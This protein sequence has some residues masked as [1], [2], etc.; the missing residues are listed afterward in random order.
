M[1]GNLLKIVG[2]VILLV[3]LKSC[4]F[5]SKTSHALKITAEVETPQGVRTGSSVIE[6][7]SKSI[8][9]WLPGS[10]G[11][12]LQLKGESPV[13]NLGNGKRLFVLL[14]DEHGKHDVMDLF[15]QPHSETDHSLTVD[16]Y[17][18]LVT[19]TDP[20]DAASVVKVS[21]ENFTGIFGDGYQLRRIFVEPVT[22]TA[23]FG[24]LDEI[25]L[26][27][28]HILK[29]PSAQRIASKGTGGQ[30]PASDPKRLMSM[31]FRQGSP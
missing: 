10:Y 5:P 21:P 3:I 7:V 2:L 6:L 26:F 18:L 4:I 23:T 15:R 28:N 19:F 20:D 31:S 16:N 29:L 27:K 22:G 24:A 14:R 8:P 12:T 9:K 13:V 30:V 17:P 1:S 25:P 11:Y